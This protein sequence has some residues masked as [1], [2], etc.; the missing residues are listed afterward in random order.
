V[1]PIGAGL[2]VKPGRGLSGSDNMC[3]GCYSRSAWSGGDSP[4]L[5][6]SFTGFR[7]VKTIF[8]AGPK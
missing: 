8:P 3:R 6:L 7:P 5:R 1:D 2:E 4:E